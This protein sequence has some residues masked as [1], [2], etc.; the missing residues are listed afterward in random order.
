MFEVPGRS[1]K[2]RLQYY[3]L[4][5]QEIIVKWQAN[6]GAQLQL[7]SCLPSIMIMINLTEKNDKKEKNDS[8]VWKSNRAHVHTD[9]AEEIVTKLSRIV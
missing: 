6:L 4:V 3:C 7:S 2:V 1:R 5:K 8:N 9:G